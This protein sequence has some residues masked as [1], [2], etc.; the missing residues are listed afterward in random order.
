MDADTKN[1]TENENLEPLS[2]Q[3]T[4]E[5]NE[6]L[7]TVDVL[8]TEEETQ[9]IDAN[10]EKREQDLIVS[11]DTYD[12]WYDKIT[13]RRMY[14]L[15]RLRSLGK[16]HKKRMEY[17]D[18]V[19]KELEQKK[20]IEHADES[21][22]NEKDNNNRSAEIGYKSDKPKTEDK[23]N[24]MN[25]SKAVSIPSAKRGGN[26]Q[27]TN[28]DNTGNSEV[29]SGTAKSENQGQT[30]I[31]KTEINDTS[32]TKTENGDINDRMV[33]ASDTTGDLESGYTELDNDTTQSLN[34]TKYSQKDMTPHIAEMVNE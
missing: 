30:S 22:L 3:N 16:T 23:R 15:A 33:S 24:E 26:G 19:K 14:A 25:N 28:G 17:Y 5:F 11:Q 31:S 13:R 12:L 18:I 1:D 20:K 2:F 10:I 34:D 27:S 4:E 9:E 32:M 21:K 6:F 29:Q 8:V 7:D